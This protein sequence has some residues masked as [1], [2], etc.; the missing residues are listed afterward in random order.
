MYIP[1]NSL[2]TAEHILISCVDFYW[3]FVKISIQL[4]ISKISSIIFILKE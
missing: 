4:L 1:C 3:S 2:L